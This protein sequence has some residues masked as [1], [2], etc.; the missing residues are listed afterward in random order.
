MHH[1]WN[2]ATLNTENK[3]E[4]GKSLP[5]VS[6][7]GYGLRWVKDAEQKTGIGHSGG[8][9]GFGSNWKILPD[10]GLGVVTFAN[11]TY[12]PTSAV[13]VH[14]LDKLVEIADLKPNPTPVSAILKQRQMEL[15]ALLPKWENAEKSGIFAENFFLDY[16]PNLLKK[17]AEPIFAKAGKILKVNE[18]I[19]ENMLRG[20]FVLVGENSNIEISFTLSPENPALIQEYHIK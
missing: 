9:P 3:G 15:I 13:N 1:P 19:A 17:E 14:I 12:A 20:C 6:A 16:F 7:Y 11:G 5:F 18:I 10:Y 4:N 8:L 2:F